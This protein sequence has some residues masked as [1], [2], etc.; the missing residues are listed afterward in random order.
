MAYIKTTWVEGSAPGIS[1]ENLN[2]L[3]TQYDEAKADLDA[4][5]SDYANPHQVT[6]AQVGLG[7][8]ENLSAEEV[9]TAS[10]YKLRAE[11]KS[12]APSS[13]ANGDIWYDST[14]HKFKGYANGAW[15]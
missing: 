4:H 1:A 2:H 3:E 5:K 14:N 9:R 15:V 10:A 8:V 12:S 6:K 11:V 13:P 7:N